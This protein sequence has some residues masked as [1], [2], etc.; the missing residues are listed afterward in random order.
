MLDTFRAAML[1]NLVHP[2]SWIRLGRI[3][4]TSQANRSVGY[5][6]VTPV[7][8]DIPEFNFDVAFNIIGQRR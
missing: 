5:C 1:G 2:E 3:N 8:K 6:D 7:L 4:E